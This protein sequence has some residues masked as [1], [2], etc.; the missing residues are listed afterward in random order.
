[1]EDIELKKLIK[2][3]LDEDLTLNE[4]HK[5]LSTEHN[6]KITFMELR[7]LS[8]EIEDMDWGKFDPKAEE[9]DEEEEVREAPV[10]VEA[11]QIEISNIQRAGAMASGTVTFLSGLKGEWYVD[12]MGQLGLNMAHEDDKPSE[13]DMQDFQTQL[14][15][16]IQGG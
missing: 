11:T 2:S 14:Q 5:I 3:H 10:P 9:E 15:R 16:Q 7:L 13:E 8:S 12:T 4:I 6:V 1:M